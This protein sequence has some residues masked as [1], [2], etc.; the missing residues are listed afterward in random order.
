[1][2]HATVRSALVASAALP[3][4]LAG[5]AGAAA[6]EGGK[7]PGGKA[8][9]EL[10]PMRGYL[11]AHKDVEEPLHLL[12]GPIEVTLAQDTGGVFV[13]LPAEREL[14]PVVFGTPEMPR[15]VGG[16]P[17]DQGVPPGVRG[18]GDGQYTQLEQM[19]PFGDEFVTMGGADLE[20][21]VVDETATDAATSQD[22]VHMSASWQDDE[23]NTYTVRCCEKLITHGLQYPTFG[24]V[25]TNHVMHGV[26]DVGTPLMPTMFAYLGFWGMGEVAKNG[27]VLDKPRVVH[28]MLTEYVRTEGYELG[29][30]EDV[31]PTGWHFHLMVAPF[32]P[33]PE[34]GRL[35]H[36]PVQTGFTL[37]NGKPLPFWHVM[38]ENFDV[39]AGRTS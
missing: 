35:E 19:T 37:P 9:H 39:E 33:V 8:W 17:M 5:V 34:Q 36:A 25:V 31:T 26:S 16:Q 32:K 23:G 29:F 14:D 21:R 2:A 27:E 24:G 6:Q 30:D 10:S 1:M 7:G 28:G 4:A 15:N 38:F 18:T 20:L 22:S 13:A 3:L 12:G 11:E